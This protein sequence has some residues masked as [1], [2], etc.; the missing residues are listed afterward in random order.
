MTDLTDMPTLSAGAVSAELEATIGRA[1]D[2]LL[3]AQQP[4]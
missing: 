2:A 1:T 4:D 3:A